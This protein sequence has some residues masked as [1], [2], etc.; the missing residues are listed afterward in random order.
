M[1]QAS[2]HY[3][4]FECLAERTIALAQLE[5]LRDPSKGYNH[6]LEYRM[7]SVLPLAQTHKVR[8]LTNMG[9]ANPEAAL[10]RVMALARELRLSGMCLSAVIGDNV[11]D[12][13]LQNPQLPQLE[14]GRP[15]GELADRILSA[16]AYLGSGPLVQALELGADVVLTGR[17]ADP[18]L[19]LA[20]MM[21]EFGWS[22]NDA[23]LLGKGT[24]VGHLLECAGQV[25]GGYFAEPIRKPV[26]EPWNLGF[27][28]AEVNA[29]G[30]GFISKAPGTGG[31]VNTA[32]CTEQLLYE[33]HDPAAYLTPDCTA[34][35]SQ[36][37][38]TETGPDQVAFSGAGGRPPTDTYKVSVGYRNGYL[39]EGQI[40]Y[41][42][43]GCVARARMAGDIVRR[44]LEGVGIQAEDLRL[45]LIG[46]N[47]I[48]PLPLKGA[49]EP[50]EVRLRVAGRTATREQAEALAGEVEALYTN[51]PAGG[52]GAVKKVEELVSVVSVLLPKSAVRPTVIHHIT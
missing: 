44:R 45:D 21:Y 2:L 12:Y 39:G 15:I 23:A 43:H 20:P 28:F 32:T 34:D 9:A 51:G 26:P 42:G 31:V 46:L 4:G 50:P 22:P 25:C 41:G 27:P 33:I 35:F 47:A 36:V 48:N 14:N 38:F 13:V 30:D 19:F 8:V 17:V 11:L 49:G 18:A 52:G 29:S 16:N 1:R 5:K 40:S 37:Q 24:L 3:I 10:E 7:R 6:L